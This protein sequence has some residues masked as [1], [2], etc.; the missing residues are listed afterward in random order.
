M[1][2]E[3]DIGFGQAGSAD[4]AKRVTMSASRRSTP[5]AE[6]GSG[7]RIPDRERATHR[8][9]YKT[10]Q[11]EFNGDRDDDELLSSGDDDDDDTLPSG[12]LLSSSLLTGGENSNIFGA[13]RGGWRNSQRRRRQ[14]SES[15]HTTSSSGS[16]DDEEEYNYGNGYRSGRRLNGYTPTVSKYSKPDLNVG[17]FGTFRNEMMHSL[18]AEL[19][20]DL[21]ESDV[22]KR[23]FKNSERLNDLDTR[24]QEVELHFAMVLEANNVCHQQVDAMLKLF[25]KMLMYTKTVEGM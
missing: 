25:Q 18:K 23:R 3:T 8:T 1:T 14:H 24:L 19:L 17:M 22:F 2:T 6:H 5:R 15:S 12:G 10:T 13:P 9:S 16:D 7:G 21:K 11:A 4:H 20:E